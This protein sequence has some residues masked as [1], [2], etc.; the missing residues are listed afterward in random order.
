MVE[1]IEMVLIEKDKLFNMW[2]RIEKGGLLRVIPEEGN[3]ERGSPMS[4]PLENWWL[5]RRLEE[6]IQDFGPILTILE[7]GVADGGGAKIWEQVLLSQ[8]KHKNNPKE[9]LYIG[10]D[11]GP[12]ILWD[13]KNSPIDMRIIADDTH[14]EETRNKVKYILIEKGNEKEI[15]KVDFLWID[16]QH[17]SEDVKRDFEDYGSF[18]KDNGI[19]GFHDTRL[20]RSFWDNFT[21]GGVD[22]TDDPKNDI[23][24]KNE[25]AVFHKEEIKYSLGTGIFWKTSDQTIVKFRDI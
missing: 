18:V 19:I 11:H 2:N 5:L 4:D 7:L 3:R 14:K 6:N 10:V 21:G 15:R 24:F 17:W 8:I 13:Y 20:M 22:A 9:L 25:K 23:G 1:G 16:A 12:N